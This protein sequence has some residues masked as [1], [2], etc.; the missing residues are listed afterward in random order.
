MSN[1]HSP[2][3]TWL[4]LYDWRR[5]VAGLYREREEAILRGDDPEA[6]LARFRAGKDALFAGHPQSPIP[7]GD[8]PRF[9][10]LRY[11][12]YNPAMR[13]DAHMVPGENPREGPPTAGATEAMP[14][15]R[16][17][18]VSFTIGGTQLQLPVYWI[19]VYGGS[20]F[21]PFRDRTA[22]G[23]T[24]G[25]GRYLFDTAKGSDFLRLDRNG[26]PATRTGEGYSGGPVVLDFNYAYNPSCAY[27][28]NWVCP[29]A[30]L[31][32]HLPVAISA[33]ERKY[34]D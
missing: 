6:V 4:D 13:V 28:P 1:T 5:Q 30:P 24:Y 17:A 26:R 2:K 23:E 16:A 20:L 29:L 9:A 32:N 34:R 33:G 25:G 11:F 7:A 19:D 22:P 12:P 31:E 8:R 3:P 21:L 18:T 15:R 10:G 14:L 27:D